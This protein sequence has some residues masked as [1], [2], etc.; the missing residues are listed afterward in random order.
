MGR[1]RGDRPDVMESQIG[2]LPRLR[3]RAALSERL[4]VQGDVEPDHEVIAWPHEEVPPW[5]FIRGLRARVLTD[6]WQP[7]PEVGGEMHVLVEEETAYCGMCE[8]IALRDPTLD[9]TRA[10]DRARPLGCGAHRR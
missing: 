3:Q 8:L 2:R 1:L 6:D 10:R 7:N 9:P 5:S 4:A